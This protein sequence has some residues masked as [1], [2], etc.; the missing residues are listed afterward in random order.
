M[1]DAVADVETD[2]PAKKSKMPL[3]IGVVLGLVGAGGGFFAVQSGLL[4]FGQ[5]AAPEKEH[6]AK[7]APEGVDKGESAEEI[8][9]LAY[10]EMEPIVITLRKASG[11]SQLRFGAQLEVDLENQ[12]E[13][14]KL[15]PRVVDVLNSY[16]RALELE[17][18]TD[19]MALPRLRAQM[20]RRINIATGQGRVRDLL[21]M[22]FVIN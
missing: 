8:A 17:D 20:L 22:N 15:L 10:I 12:E 1:T 2:E 16:L 21:I 5:S 9:N 7:E 14:E 4:P 19:P 13:V 11:I 3:I 6:V 18:L